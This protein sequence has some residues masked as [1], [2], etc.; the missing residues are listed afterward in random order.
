MTDTLNNE[1]K[2]HCAVVLAKVVAARDL[3]APISAKNALTMKA[4]SC[5]KEATILLALASYCPSDPAPTVAP[6]IF[7]P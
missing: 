3:F 2:N 5:L 7:R 6:T 1:E 4:E